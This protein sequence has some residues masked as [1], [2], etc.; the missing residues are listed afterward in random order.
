MGYISHSW[1]I[2]ERLLHFAH[3]SVVNSMCHMKLA[4]ILCRHFFLSPQICKTTRK[5]D[6]HSWTMHCWSS[7]HSC[8]MSH[9]RGWRGRGRRKRRSFWS[10]LGA[11]GPASRLCCCPAYH[12]QRGCQFHYPCQCL[13]CSDNAMWRKQC[14]KWTFHATCYLHIIILSWACLFAVE[15]AYLFTSPTHN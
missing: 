3:T 9:D 8:R 12:L 15:H 2:P 11:C 1:Y 5:C 6:T 13:L 10:W 14:Y 4:N 7:K